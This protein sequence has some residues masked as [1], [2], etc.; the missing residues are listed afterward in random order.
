MTTWIL[1]WEERRE[2]VLDVAETVANW[3]FARLFAECV[4]K[5]H[6][7]PIRS[8][9]SIDE[10]AF[11]QVV[12]RFERFLQNVRSPLSGHQRNHGL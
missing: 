9:R 5:S 10:Q 8:Q 2:A 4:D 1:T 11:E 3:G 12:S 6:F 7:D